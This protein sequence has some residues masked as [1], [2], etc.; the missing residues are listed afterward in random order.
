[1]KALASIAKAANAPALTTKAKNA[2]I[3]ALAAKD[4]NAELSLRNIGNVMTEEV[5]NLNVVDLAT[6]KFVI[7]EK[8]SES[9]ATLSARIAKN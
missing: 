3:I 5:R 8:P 7:I 4:A 1:V 6:K 9:I 2:A